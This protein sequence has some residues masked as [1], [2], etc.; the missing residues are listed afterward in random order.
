MRQKTLS[1]WLKFVVIAVALC[2]LAADFL[3]IPTLG[4]SWVGDDP[5]LEKM[6]WPWLIFA[7]VF[8]VPCFAALV[9]GWKIA[10][11]IGRDRSFSKQNADYMKKIAYLAGGDT[12]F[13][14]VTETVFLFL[15]LSHPGVFLFSFLVVLIGAAITVAAAVLSHLILKAARL[16]DEN[17]LTI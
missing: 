13:F 1:N 10:V 4:Q 2:G 15:N 8:S 6:F 9:Y 5:H 7:W 17:D 14:F 3:I 11:N 12:I 16:Q